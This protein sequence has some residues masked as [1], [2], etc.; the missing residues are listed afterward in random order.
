MK[1]RRL[2]EDFRVEECT[3]FPLSEQGAYA[4]YRL[5]KRGI[6]TPEA[7][8]QILRKWNVARNR[9]SYGGMKDRHAVTTQSVTIRNG[10]SKSLKLASF[11]LEYIGRS[12][13]PF[14]ANDIAGNKFEMVIRSLSDDEVHL[15]LDAVP[16]V[17]RTGVPNYFDDQRFGSLTPDGEFIAA[18]WLKKDYERALWLTFAAYNRHDRLDERKQKELL[19]ENW[20]NWSACKAAL[21][22]SHRRSIITFLDDRP[23]DFRGAWARVR[24]DMRSLY[25][26]AFQSHLWNEILVA[27]LK[28][29]C[30]ADCLIPYSLKHSEVLFFHELNPDLLQ[31]IADVSLPLPSGRHK[32]ETGPVTALVVETLAAHGWT[33]DELRVRYPKDSFLSKSWRQAIIRIPDLT[34]AGDVDELSP[35]RKKLTLTFT[36]PRGSYATILIKRLTNVAELAIDDVETQDDESN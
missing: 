20:G 34:A 31:Q 24:P 6:G 9:V 7:I 3:A 32:L 28:Q 17:Q 11:S 12:Q 5:E 13:R 36:L 14:T 35:Q 15:A 16:D 8:D 1:L 10:M 21:E 30:P 25:L 23:G 22:R 4:V 19:R 33:M 27:L 29:H 18:A 26:S 2:P